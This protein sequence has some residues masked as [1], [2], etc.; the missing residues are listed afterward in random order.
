MCQPL[1]AQHYEIDIHWNLSSSISKTGK[2]TPEMTDYYNRTVNLAN[3]CIN[4]AL[5]IGS[6]NAPSVNFR[7]KTL[8][9]MEKDFEERQIRQAFLAFEDEN[10]QL[11]NGIGN[12]QSEIHIFSSLKAGY[13]YVPVI[14]SEKLKKL[15]ADIPKELKYDGFLDGDIEKNKDNPFVMSFAEEFMRLW[16][17]YLEGKNYFNN[18][19]Y[20][21]PMEKFT[22]DDDAYRWMENLSGVLAHE[23]LHAWGGLNDTYTSENGEAEKDNSLMAKI[24]NAEDDGENEELLGL[25][26]T[27]SK[28]QVDNIISYLKSKSSNGKL[29]F[30]PRLRQE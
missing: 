22:Q 11:I 23:L 17:D 3:E 19:I 8:K 25:N 5:F 26:C 15:Y 18:V 20:L 12:F 13:N 4:K 6:S 9:V 29:S 14:Y 27:L 28:K 30:T 7:L 2:I 21:Y 1:F 10:N 16:T 24:L